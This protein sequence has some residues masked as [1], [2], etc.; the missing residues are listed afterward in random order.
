MKEKSS[1]L[2]IFLVLFILVL[3]LP[4]MAAIGDIRTLKVMV[5]RGPND[6]TPD[7]T[8]S[9][10]NSSVCTVSPS[11]TYVE[12]NDNGTFDVKEFEIVI[13][14]KGT[15]SITIMVNKTNYKSPTHIMPVDSEVSTGTYIIPFKLYPYITTSFIM[16]FKQL[17]LTA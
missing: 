10:S 14:G 6:Y 11:R 13:T 8:V 17:F 2:R 5:N 1:I 9:S 15:C 12:T 4:V 7:I 16:F 3:N